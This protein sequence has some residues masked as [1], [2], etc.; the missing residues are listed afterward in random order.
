VIDELG[1]LPLPDRAAAALFQEVSQRY[2]KTFIVMTNIRGVGSP[3]QVSG[4][5]GDAC[6]VGQGTGSGPRSWSRGQ[7][8][9]EHPTSIPLRTSPTEMSL[10]R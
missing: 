7:P 5:S 4:A 6:T 1:Y 8:S 10:F 9:S 2:V 3:T